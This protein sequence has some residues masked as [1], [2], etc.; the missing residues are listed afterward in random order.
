MAIKSI[1]VCNFKSFDELNVDLCDFNVLIGQ[2]ASGK[3]NF[4]EIFRFLRDICKYGLINAISIQGGVTYL[5]NVKLKNF[6]EMVFEIKLD[7]E[8]QII[9]GFLEEK[10]GRFVTL[11]VKETSYSFSIKFNTRGTGFQISN[12]RLEQR[13]ELTELRVSKKGNIREGQ[14]FGEAIL[15]YESHGRKIKDSSKLP[16]NMA[17][18]IGF[19]PPF[20]GRKKRT[21]GQRELMLREVVR[22]IPIRFLLENIGCYDFDPK[23]SKK[24]VSITGKA[25]LEEDGSNLAISLKN[26]SELKRQEKIKFTRLLK[27]ILPFVSDWGVI[28]SADKSIVFT[29]RENFT[30]VIL[31]SP[32][33]SDG[34]VNITA[35]ILA[36]YFGNRQLTIIEEPER[37]I[38]PS[39]LSRLIEMSEDVS[40]FKQV[41]LSTHS[42]EIVKFVGLD[43][44]LLVSRTKDGYSSIIKPKESTAVKTFLKNDMGIDELFV[45]NLLK[46]IER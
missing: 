19:F 37:A 25:S 32:F 5:R 31:P 34:T 7:D 18:S 28:R 22:A 3:S 41:L 20:E 23:L 26:I 39:L 29:M 14:S 4:I 2:N 16:S 6:R 40:S 46:E 43:N 27:S 15:V 42:A 13:G 36:L 38:H 35:M 30:D 12:E 45:D 11:Q 21:L 8:Y 33:L 24:A 44:L 10:K 9:P 1:R 17:E